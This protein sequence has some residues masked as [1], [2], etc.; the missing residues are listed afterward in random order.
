MGA[1]S[2]GLEAGVF[3]GTALLLAPG[4]EMVN[5]NE[6]PA[7]RARWPIID[8]GTERRDPQPGQATTVVSDLVEA[9]EFY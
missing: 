4:V 8:L 1:A 2:C 7:Q 6:Q 3:A 9:I 5:A